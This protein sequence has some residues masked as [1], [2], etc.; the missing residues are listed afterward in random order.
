MTNRH[1]ARKDV[2]IRHVV[3][4]D[5]ARAEADRLFEQLTDLAGV[6]M[7]P[8]VSAE[9]SWAVAEWQARREAMFEVASVYLAEV[10]GRTVGFLA[11]QH[12]ELLDLSV[13]TLLVCCIDPEWQSHGIAFTLNLRLLLRTWRRSRLRPGFIV[14]RVLNPKALDGW[15]SQLDDHRYFWPRIGDAPEP[16]PDLERV[17]AEYLR[18][19]E[20]DTKFD[21][22]GSV[23]KA[24]HPPGDRVVSLSGNAVVDQHYDH[25]VDLDAGDTVL[26][27][28]YLDHSVIRVHLRR[29]L[30]VMPRVLFIRSGGAPP[31]DSR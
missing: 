18:R 15:R 9:Q 6:A 21:W 16:I 10:E 17:V 8:G 23:L 5:L 20:P 27:A 30:T 28:I 14:A 2:R 3:L 7:T 22:E 12:D 13:L 29:L 26:M 31:D 1:L 24:R 25:F 4:K 19:H 11:Y